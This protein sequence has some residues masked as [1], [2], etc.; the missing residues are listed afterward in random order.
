MY[1]I[2][3]PAYDGRGTKPVVG[4]SWSRYDLR[5][6]SY[7][8][9]LDR[10]ELVIIEDEL[11]KCRYFKN[12]EDL[13]DQLISQKSVPVTYQYDYNAGSRTARAM[14]ASPPGGWYSQTTKPLPMTTLFDFD[15]EEP[16]PTKIPK[17]ATPKPKTLSET[18]L[19]KS[20]V[21]RK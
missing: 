6:C 5:G 11:V 21:K 4:T 20:V 10:S 17:R 13:C 18:I 16:A 9:I 19:E 3:F 12:L 2:H 8:E 7:Q 1:K 15:G 14:Q